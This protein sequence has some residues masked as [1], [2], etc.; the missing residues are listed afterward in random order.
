MFSRWPQSTDRNH[1]RI[2]HV[3]SIWT[4]ILLFL[5]GGDHYYDLNDEADKTLTKLQE[6]YGA[7]NVRQK[8]SWYTRSDYCDTRIMQALTDPS[9]VF[10]PT[11]KMVVQEAAR[12][13]NT[14]LLPQRPSRE[15]DSPYHDHSFGRYEATG[16]PDYYRR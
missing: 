3:N 16:I 14:Y 1:R 4:K 10:L 13:G 2:I 5:E 6:K 7:K 8:L 9:D 12:Q 11:D 15:E